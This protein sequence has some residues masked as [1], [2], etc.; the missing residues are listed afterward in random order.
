LRVYDEAILHCNSAIRQWTDY[1]VSVN[2]NEC[3]GDLDDDGDVDLV[4]LAT[5][6]GVYGT[7]CP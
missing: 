7:T 1:L 2:V 3:L 6:L 4:D 5:L